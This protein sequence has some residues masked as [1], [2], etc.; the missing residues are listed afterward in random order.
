MPKLKILKFLLLLILLG[1][2]NAVVAEERN[3][4]GAVVAVRGVV[5]AQS[6]SGTPRVLGRDGDLVTGE[7][8]TTS[9]RS[10]AV[11][12]LK[13]G[14]RMSLRP[15]T[16]FKVSSWNEEPQKESAVFRLFKGGLRAISGALA[17]RNPRAFRLQTSV[18]TI[19]IR[20][21][22]FDVRLCEGGC[23]DDAEKYKEVPA[24]ISAVVGRVGF[25]K[26]AVNA[27]RNEAGLERQLTIGAPIY[28][29]D[30]VTTKEK[31][32]TVLLFKDKSRVTLR[33]NSEFMV[34]SLK[35]KGGPEDT[36]I[37]RL[38][39]GG[40]R[41]VTGLVGKRRP[42][43]VKYRTAIATIGIRGT[44]FDM[45]CQGSCESQRSNVSG[46]VEIKH[47]LSEMLIATAHAAD[48]DKPGLIVAPWENS[49]LVERPEGTIVIEQGQIMLIPADGSEPIFLVALPGEIE[50]PR[51]EDVEIDEDLLLAFSDPDVSETGLYLACQEGHCLMGEVPLGEGEAAFKGE[52]PDAKPV[53]F[54]LI[55]QFLTED[56]YFKTVDI[57]PEILDVFGVANDPAALECTVQ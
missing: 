57:D 50:E 49:V 33:A 9:E 1:N 28:E 19:G 12:R 47:L 42:A 24:K 46:I 40:L 23:K 4:A 8:I 16:S 41:A 27:V 14:T 56:P 5:T 17:K 30:T 3:K 35:Y 20:G 7:V 11:L 31:S 55:P 21:T 22:T 51:P 6:D 10:F 43:S 36:A 38:V 48:E 45:Y 25:I 29:G 15:N 26:G 18:A 34:S 39:R 53:R 13:D 52:G 44:G 54:E 2:T 37:F 32:F